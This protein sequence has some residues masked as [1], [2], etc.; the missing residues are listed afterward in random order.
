MLAPI[1]HLEKP[2]DFDSFWQSQLEK[3]NQIPL[4]VHWIS[5]TLYTEEIVMKHFSIV[6]FTRN[7]LHGYVLMPKRAKDRPCIVTNHG[8]MYNGGQP[9]EHLHFVEDGY[10]V[11]T[12]DVRGQSGLS[13]DN[14]NYG[15]GD[16]RLMT[17]GI[18]DINQYYMM[19]VYMDALRVVQ[20]AK[21][22]DQVD[23]QKI[24][25]HGASQGGGIALAVAALDQSVILSLA[26]VPS[27][28]YLPGRLATRNGS[29]SEI[30][31]FIDE[32]HLSTN[33]ALK[34]LNYID[35]VHHASNIVSPVIISTGGQDFICPEA[36]F[37][38][39]Y[40]K[41]QSEK[42]L[43]QYPNAGHEGGGSIHLHIKRT[44]IKEHLYECQASTRNT[45]N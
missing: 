39:T 36:Y 30:A 24:I 25:V 10:C 14:F 19:H 41:I 27:Y 1:L 23:N 7:L 15:S 33:E 29:I 31:S 38:P 2:R 4:H 34:T 11:V 6:G 8:Y 43:Y 18:K 20:F 42:R 44:W 17:R 5:E 9:I 26:D 16:H 32:G 21:S 12:Y 13:V 45:D 22:L 37:M 35:L 40:H 3:S 28:S